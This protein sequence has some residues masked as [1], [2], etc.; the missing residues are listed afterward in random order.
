MATAYD[1]PID[2]K[3]IDTYVPL[4]FQEMM[5]HSA[6]LR[7]TYDKNLDSLDVGR[8]TLAAIEAVG[9]AAKQELANISSGYEGFA[10]KMA[11]GDLTSYDAKRQ[12]KQQ[13][14]QLS[15]DPGLKNIISSTAAIKDAQKRYQ[16]VASDP[17]FK[18]YYAQ[19]FTKAMDQYGKE[20]SKSNI[21]FGNINFMKPVDV[22]ETI[23]KPIF[24][25]I[26]ADADVMGKGFYE[27]KNKGIGLA[28]I[29]KQ[30]DANVGQYLSNR[31]VQMDLNNAISTPEGAAEVAGRFDINL[32][33]LKDKGVINETQFA[34]YK[35]APIEYKYAQNRLLGSG[36]ERI[37]N[38][39]DLTADQVKLTLAQM[40]QARQIAA[41]KNKGKEQELFNTRTG[42]AYNQA[43]QELAKRIKS[44]DTKQ[45]YAVPLE[46]YGKSML[47]TA[48]PQN[49]A[50][51]VYK[52]AFNLPNDKFDKRVVIG[53][54]SIKTA[55]GQTTNIPNGEILSLL[56]RGVMRFGQ[57]NDGRYAAQGVSYV[58]VSQATWEKYKEKFATKDQNGKIVSVDES[59]YKYNPGV[60]Q[61]T[62]RF[63]E[64]DAVI[65]EK[66]RAGELYM[67][68]VL[69]ESVI[70]D[71]QIR[72]NMRMDLDQ[73][74]K[75]AAESE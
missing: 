66:I 27:E 73:T 36:K 25:Q 26:Q 72:E 3:L 38:E 67:I 12:I 47:A 57:I 60:T 23:E 35:N 10:E 6:Q 7:D 32:Q 39:R 17:N 69:S 62:G 31:Q 74:N 34:E 44:G 8:S 18:S 42:N 54:H 41:D 19:D 52:F 1:K 9:P 68:P 30:A 5:Q 58:A 21:D 16:A 11:A 63:D 70:E 55:N 29:F 43:T 49:R 53:K 2:N 59:K 45:A 37:Y 14:S 4:P 28:K 71:A 65:Q 64:N 48:I 56:P 40:A 51:E 33:E 61:V 15:N 46:T 22:R 20:G 50:E 13:V 75:R 24:D